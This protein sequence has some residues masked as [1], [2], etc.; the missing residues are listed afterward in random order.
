LT[1]DVVA[2]VKL[3]GETFTTRIGTGVGLAGEDVAVDGG[4]GTV[5]PDS[6]IRPASPLATMLLPMTLI[7][8]NDP[9]R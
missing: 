2:D 1:W 5:A 6:D 8:S 9:L 4:V 7:E 3:F